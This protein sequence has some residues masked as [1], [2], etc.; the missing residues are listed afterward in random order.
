MK[1]IKIF[2]AVFILSAVAVYLSGCSSAEQTTAKIAYNRGDYKKAEV[3]F[4]KETKQNPQNEEAWFYLA[5]SRAQLNNSE[6]TKTAITQYRS[7]GK[8]SFN[9][10]LTDMWGIMC[11]KGHN[12]FTAVK[13]F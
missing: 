10:E 13:N 7:V 12:N 1:F 4:D 6:G 2:S 11:D 8:N 3:E 5:M 9:S